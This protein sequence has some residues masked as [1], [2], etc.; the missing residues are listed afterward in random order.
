[1]DYNLFD[2]L[3]I[4]QILAPGCLSDFPVLSAY[5]AKMAARPKLQAYRQTEAFKTRKV[6]GNDNQ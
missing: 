5:Y 1:V 6:N 3:D 2:L 4:H